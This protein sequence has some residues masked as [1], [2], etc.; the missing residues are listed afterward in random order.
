MVVGAV[1]RRFLMIVKIAP[2][3]RVAK[4]L[5]LAADFADFFEGHSLFGVFQDERAAVSEIYFLGFPVC[6][7]G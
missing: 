2:P 6:G 3:V 4:N 5:F 1:H 7:G